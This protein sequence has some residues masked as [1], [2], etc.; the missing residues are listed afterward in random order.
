[1]D[2]RAMSQ[3]PSF[4]KFNTAAAQRGWAGLCYSDLAFERCELAA[5]AALWHA[6]AEGRAIPPRSDFD[7]RVLKPYLTNM[8][9]LERVADAA[10]QRRFRA[11]LHG[12]GLARFAGDS[13]GRFL[14]EQIPGLLCEGY[15]A[16]YS[17]VLD[18]ARPAR[19]LWDY[20]IPAISYL[21]GE[22]FVAPLS[23]RD[24]SASLLLSVTYTRAKETALAG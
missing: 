20:Q 16:L 3:S 23:A 14:E 1:V 13:T 21:K 15:H 22:S 24:G 12:T 8:T 17:F 19:V 7:A 6:K 9:I 18:E 5:V 10:G 2:F 4:A 11:R